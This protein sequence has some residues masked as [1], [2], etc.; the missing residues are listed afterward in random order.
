MMLVLATG[1]FIGKGIFKDS[2]M[3]R[4]SDGTMMSN[5][6]DM[7]SMM[8]DMNAALKGKTGDDFDQAFLREMIIHHEGAVDMARQVLNVSKRPELIQLA[9]EIITAQTKEIEMMKAWQ[10]SWFK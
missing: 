8:H 5:R 10:L 7:T 3:H 1:I 4:M 6:V 2:G 9:Q